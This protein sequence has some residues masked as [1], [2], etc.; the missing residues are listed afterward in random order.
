[1][2][3]HELFN[4]VY[5]EVRKLGLSYQIQETGGSVTIKIT[6][7]KYNFKQEN[8]ETFRFRN[9]RSFNGS[10]NSNWRSPQ[11]FNEVG[12]K[13]CSSFPNLEFFQVTP[14]PSPQTPT[15]PPP[16]ARPPV[17]SPSCPVQRSRHSTSTEP[18]PISQPVTSTPFNPFRIMK[19][20][21]NFPRT[22]IL[23]KLSK[24]ENQAD[25]VLDISPESNLIL[26]P[27]NESLHPRNNPPDESQENTNDE[28][29]FTP[30]NIEALKN[31][32]TAIYER[33]RF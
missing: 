31:V 6:R 25:S 26:S 30:E 22:P 10:S 17:S 29:S 4:S 12:N 7:D 2:A 28:N 11:K 13:T 23:L 8:R 15:Y 18:P 9:S 14:A 33:T 3:I 24:S 20:V 19:R 21:V 16:S 5:D 32:M 27:A 1:M